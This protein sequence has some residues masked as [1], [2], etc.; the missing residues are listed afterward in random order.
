M[1]IL[2]ASCRRSF[3]N[4]ALKRDAKARSQE[5]SSKQKSESKFS[6]GA[7]LE[8]GINTVILQQLKSGAQVVGQGL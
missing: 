7:L 1:V 6:L 3:S 5:A 2:F 4:P 8:N